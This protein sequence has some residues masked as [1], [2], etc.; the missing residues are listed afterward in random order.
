MQ[1]DADDLGSS[2]LCGS[3]EDC[4]ETVLHFFLRANLGGFQTIFNATTQ[5]Q[6]P[7]S[8]WMT[9]DSPSLAM[10]SLNLLF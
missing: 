3:I 7:E 6:G 4:L 10:V 8:G 1:E 5:H 2:L 9:C